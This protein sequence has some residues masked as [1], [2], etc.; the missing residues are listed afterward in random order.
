MSAAVDIG[1]LAGRVEF[2]DRTSPT[3]DLIVQKIDQL[4]QRFGSLNHG[5]AQVAEGFIVGELAMK[6]FEHGLEVAKELVRDFTTEGVHIAEVERSFERLT[7]GAGQLGSTLIGVLREGTHNTITDFELMKAVNNNLANGVKLTDDQYRE[8]ATGAF[9]LAQSKGIGV[10]EAFDMINE[11][12]TRGNPRALRALGITTDLANAEL[13]YALKL[14]KRTEQLTEAEKVEARREAI[15]AAVGNATARLGDQT[16][17]LDELLAQAHV[18]WSNFYEDL[19]KSAATSP[20]VVTAFTT[21]RDAV[22][23]ALGGDAKEAVKVFMGW[24]NSAADTVT[25]WVPTVVSGFQT[26][27]DW[28]VDFY[29]AASSAWHTYG[30]VI[31]TSFRTIRDWLL[32]VYHEVIDT[33]EG[34]PTWLKVVAERSALTAVGLY[35]MAGAADTAAGGINTLISNAGNLTQTFTGLP[36]LIGHIAEGFASLRL[37]GGLTALSFE[38][39]AAAVIS[40]KL[41]GAAVAGTLGPVGLLIGYAAALFAAFELGKMQRISDFFQNIWL[42]VMGYNAAE[43]AAMIETD[44]LTQAQAAQ[45]VVADEQRLAQDKVNAMLGAMAKAQTEVAKATE[46]HAD[47]EHD[48]N[49]QLSASDREKYVV[50]WEKLNALASNYDDVLLALEPTLAKSVKEYAAAGAAVE[51]L[52]A[53]FPGLTKAQAEA[54]VK[55]ATTA[56][57]IA[58]AYARMFTESSK[59]HGDNI[60]GFIHGEQMKLDV[61]LDAAVREGTLTRELELQKRREFQ[62]TVDLE[63]YGREQSDTNSRVYYQHQLELAQAD[64]DLKMK[65]ILDYR[66]AE[67][68]DSAARLREAKEHFEH[69]MFYADNAHQE[70]RAQQAQTQTQGERAFNSIA[71]AVAAMNAGLDASKIKVRTLGG[72]FISLAEAKARFEKGGSFDVT[73]A[74]FDKALNDYLTN[75]GWNPSSMGMNRY[76]DPVMLAHGGYSFAEVLKYAFDK[77]YQGA[78]PPPQGPRIP[79]FREGGYGDF[80]D[81]TLVELHGK[82]I[83]TPVDR[84]GAMGNMTLVFNV[85]GTA[86][87]AWDKIK[88]IAMRELKPMR[89]FGSA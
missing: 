68:Q 25:E 84:V 5:V 67:I 51:D 31:I 22:V 3:L 85:N 71:E 20:A 87:E 60:Y 79:G 63:V 8:L 58:D 47:A 86:A 65:M 35:F 7:A 32:D 24:I 73:S 55:A 52:T 2:D 10:A 62:Q 1:T 57:A 19:L 40:V 36:V 11:S 78:L 76:R 13:D 83:I 17:G 54:A 77:N 75:G 33:W 88:T 48:L 14:G 46:H 29:D 64:Y 34:L 39:V 61:A 26:V 28:I 66:A 59:A 74:N 12:I 53:A 23:D 30:P 82:E 44:H 16:D 9:A 72:E 18:A 4:E 70:L 89:K 69:W 38:S 41:I 81:G 42:G 15:L 21:I 56:R 50:S 80:G 49:V 43:R 6:V 45:T 37:L 27:R